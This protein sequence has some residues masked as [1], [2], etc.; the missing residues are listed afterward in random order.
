MNRSEKN[1]FQFKIGIEKAESVIH[2]LKSE[3]G[4]DKWNELINSLKD[5]QSYSW[6]DFEDLFIEIGR[7]L[8]KKEN[9]TLR[10]IV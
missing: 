10:S 4:D 9:N 3:I 1:P 7:P 8:M 5:K 6:S 2:K